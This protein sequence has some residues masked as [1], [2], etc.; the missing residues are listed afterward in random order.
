MG[1]GFQGEEIAQGQ[2]KKENMGYLKQFRVVK[3]K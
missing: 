3:T 2:G 1:E